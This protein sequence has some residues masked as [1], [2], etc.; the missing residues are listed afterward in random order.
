MRNLIVALA[1]IAAQPA[2]ADQYYLSIPTDI[3][4]KMVLEQDLPQPAQAV[5]VDGKVWG[6]VDEDSRAVNAYLD[7]ATDV[8]VVGR[9]QKAMLRKQCGG[10]TPSCFATILNET[11]HDQETDQSTSEGQETPRGAG[12]GEAGES[13]AYTR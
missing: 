8:I 11:G 5:V 2:I 4:A 12:T 9:E 13:V 6:F 7:H 10:I 3:M 1:I